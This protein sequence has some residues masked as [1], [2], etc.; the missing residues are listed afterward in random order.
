MTTIKITREVR[1]LLEDYKVDGESME[2]AVNR[3]LDEVMDE[4]GTDMV[5]GG[6]STNINVSRDTMRRIKSFSVR[7]GES[8]GRILHRA[9][10]LS[11]KFK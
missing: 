4:L 10:L 5:F 7:D 1:L 3:L 2:V 11:D 9:L 6:G 8:Y